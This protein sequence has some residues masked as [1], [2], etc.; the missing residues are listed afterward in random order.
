MRSRRRSLLVAIAILG[1]VLI[2]V[3]QLRS[4]RTDNDLLS[5]TRPEAQSRITYDRFL[6]TFGSD[7]FILVAYSGPG[8]FAAEAL[9]LGLE[10]VERLEQIDGVIRVFGPV[11]LYRDVF[12]AE[13]PEALVEELSN[14]D[15]YRGLVVSED[16]LTAG[17]YISVDPPT[18]ARERRNLVRAVH[19]AIEPLESQGYET[20]CVGP[21]TLTAELDT[22][23]VSETSRSLPIA[24]LSSLFFLG[25]ILRSLR[26]TLI[27]IACS[28]STIVLTLAIPSTLGRPLDLF[29]SAL[30]ALLWVLSLA[31]ILHVLVRYR[32]ELDRHPHE[33][34]LR[35][36]VSGAR[37]PCGLS[38]ATTAA[39]FFSL[40]AAPLEP[41]RT[42]GS[43]AA[44]GILISFFMA[45]VLGPALIDILRPKTTSRERP[46]E[47]LAA[48]AG[49]AFDHPLQ[50][51][52]P[53]AALTVAGLV[54]LSVLNP[55]SNPLAF[56]PADSEVLRDYRFVADHLSGMSAIE[57]RLDTPAGWNHPETW[58]RIDA[59][60]DRLRAHPYVAKIRTPTDLLRKLNQWDQDLDPDFYDLPP[61]R[62]TSL[63]L[64]A[65]ADPTLATEMRSLVAADGLSVRLSVLVTAMESETFSE[66]E[67]L[68][69]EAVVSEFGRQ[70]K[71]TGIVSLLV[72]AQNR[73][74]SSQIRSLALASLTILV[75]IW[76]GLGSLR[77]ASLAMIPNLVPVA[78]VL[79]LMT[80]FG[81]P[82]DPGTLMVAGVA[83]GIAVDDTVHVVISV[84]RR[85]ETR[86]TRAAIVS[87]VREV[88]TAL[89]VTTAAAAVG[90][91]SLTP[92]NF[93][94]IRY[95]GFLTA[96]AMIVALFSDLAFLPSLIRLRENQ[97]G[98]DQ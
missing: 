85:L 17:L 7:E 13:D 19:S 73:L 53:F 97:R 56:F 96:A 94:P 18:S 39:G 4:L 22:A 50:I 15:F 8:V 10:V 72:G 82:L 83:L 26:G 65:D 77:W 86:N 41:V 66:I 76:V 42:L 58:E 88:G 5:W 9:D 40:N 92:A 44:I 61:T 45:F 74:L 33:E 78:T 48:M 36:A 93:L 90:F 87:A 70:A 38:S 34:A 68:A 12:G 57:L 28:F 3:W 79:L 81:L 37:F 31:A 84:R 63:R 20:H 35:L 43:L 27:A 62:A 32:R 23:S 64:I 80:V 24:A 91:L 25:L 14:T 51:T 60:A 16:L 55:S 46:A 6:Q 67:V 1:A 21:P 69:R 47:R 11:T 49:H 71:V 52:L 2:G 29:T 95:F 89:T 98:T 75:F 30:P 54:C 59:V